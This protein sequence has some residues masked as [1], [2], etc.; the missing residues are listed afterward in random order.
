MN[1]SINRDTIRAAY[2][3]IRSRVRRTPVLHTAAGDF[4]LSRPLTLKLECLQ[5]AGS[6]KPRGVFNNLLSR[7]IPPAGLAAASGGNHGAAVAYGASRLARQAKVFVP[8]TASA[9]KVERIRELGADLHVEGSEYADAAAL[10]AAY[11][12]E[13][14]AMELHPYDSP[15]TIA[16]Q[17]TL[18]LEWDE[19][20]FGLDTVLIAVGGGGLIAGAASWFGDKVKVVGVEPEGAATLHAA[21]AAGEPVDIEVNSIAADSL[22]ARRAGDLVFDICREGVAEVVLVSDKAIRTAQQAL[23]RDLRLAIE[24][25]AAAAL[26]ALMSGAYRPEPAERIGVLV[27]GGNVD[28][29]TLENHS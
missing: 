11:V 28:L 6:F 13:T 23:W 12:A 29:A 4:G 8:E 3:R 9:A 2:S 14:G 17:G 20:T 25:G 21:R 22:G 16:G 7:D 24:P 1:D 15:Q 18:A 27:C 26:S 5:H 19:Q 10:C